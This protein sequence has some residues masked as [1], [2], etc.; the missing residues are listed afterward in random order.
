EMPELIGICDRI[1]VM[2]GGRIVGEVQGDHMTENEI[3]QL[4]TGVNVGAGEA[5]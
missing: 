3:V 1:L 5:A 4:A 2:R